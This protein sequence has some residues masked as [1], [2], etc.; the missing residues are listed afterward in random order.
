MSVIVM[1]LGVLCALGGLMLITLD[2]ATNGAYFLNYA[3]FMAVAYGMPRWFG[4]FLWILPIYV[5]ILLILSASLDNSLKN[6]RR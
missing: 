2:M 1:I 6:R 5:G 3:I 4:L